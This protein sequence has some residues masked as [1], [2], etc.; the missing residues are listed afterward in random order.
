MTIRLN[1]LH[2]HTVLLRM[3]A[4]HSISLD[5]NS[6]K[7]LVIESARNVEMLLSCKFIEYEREMHQLKLSEA[8][9]SAVPVW[10]SFIA[11]D[12]KENWVLFSSDF[13]AQPLHYTQNDKTKALA[14]SLWLWTFSQFIFMTCHWF[15]GSEINDVMRARSSKISTFII[16]KKKIQCKA[17]NGLVLLE[18]LFFDQNP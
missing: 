5:F 8:I 11:F 15:V 7:S 4:F 18:N 10:V 13:Y 12:L 1:C 14:V 3:H 17:P 9:F 2:K 16:T 6:I